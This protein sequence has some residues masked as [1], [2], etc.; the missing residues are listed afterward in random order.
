[1]KQTYRTM[2]EKQTLSREAR[3]EFFEKLAGG[4]RRTRHPLRT[5]LVAACLC[6]GLAGT[7]LAVG[8]VTDGFAQPKTSV[9]P[10]QVVEVIGE[11]SGV[12]LSS[13]RV[14]AAVALRGEDGL[15]E[16]VKE[17]LAA[18]T[19]VTAWQDRDGLESYLG[20][21]MARNPLLDEAIIVA[22][23]DRD[24]RYGWNL[25][26][27]VAADT[28]AR[29]IVNGIAFDGT[30]IDADPDL[31]RV[32]SHR[33]VDNREVY[34]R[35]YLAAGEGEISPDGLPGEEFLP[36]PLINSELVQDENGEWVW[37]TEHY[38]SA[39][40][41]FTAAA[42]QMKNGTVATIVTTETVGQGFCEYTGYFVS[43]G[44]LYSVKP[45]GVYDPQKDSGWSTC[46]RSLD[47]LKQVLDE[48]K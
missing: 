45:S 48:F 22:G 4:T 3:A 2:M 31:I 18:G 34:I 6:V 39:E 13:Y 12:D 27:E 28:T 26:P 15:S 33:V 9:P 10:Q 19:L 46:T 20:A 37:K 1:M 42:Y 41:K 44:V 47:V 29:Y 5:A 24:L 40:K 17:D 14:Q 32:T 25:C 38:R 11:I 35:A 7:V 43:D 23:L 30:A 8:Y 21:Q 16:T 36:E